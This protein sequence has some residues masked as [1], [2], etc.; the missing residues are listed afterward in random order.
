MSCFGLVSSSAFGRRGILL[1]KA[2]S[3][4]QNIAD[5]LFAES[6]YVGTKSIIKPLYQT[7]EVKNAKN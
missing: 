6:C 1:R 2:W 4:G 5:G 3:L 7:M